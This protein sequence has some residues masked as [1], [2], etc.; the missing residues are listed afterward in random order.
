MSIFKKDIS[1][2]FLI[3][4]VLLY[5]TG[6]AQSEAAKAMDEQILAIGE[7]TS[8]SIHAIEAAE[9]AYNN[10]SEKEQRQVK[11]RKKLFAARDAYSQLRA[12]EADAYINDIGEVTLDSKKA[13]SNAE[14]FLD[15]LTDDECS[16]VKRIEALSAAR[17]SFSQLK[18]AEVDSLIKSI[19]IVTIDSKSDIDRA[20][21]AYRAL[22]DDER[23]FVEEREALD[24]AKASYDDACIKEVENHILSALNDTSKINDAESAYKRLPDA[25]K[26]RVSNYALLQQK[27]A[28]IVVSEIEKIGEVTL[29]SKELI[30]AAERAYNAL[31]DSTRKLVNNYNKLTDAQAS[32]TQL[33]KQ[34]MEAQKQRLLSKMNVRTDEVE[35]MTW[36]HSKSKP[37]YINT[38]SYVL[39]YIGHPSKLSDFPFLRLVYVYAGRDWVFYKKAIIVTDNSKYTQ[40]FNYF[41]VQ[42][43]TTFGGNLCE[44]VD[45][46]ADDNTIEMLKDIASSQKA[47]IRFEGDTHYSDFTVSESD[48]QA[49]QDVIDLYELLK[50]S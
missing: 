12:D 18:A 24:S 40:A 8:E 49:I 23:A 3:L 42:R 14:A 32:F 9:K 33:K 13:I 2:V 38:R 20:E 45:K 50:A 44:Y 4:I 39:P 5:S 27:K 15:S 10:M 48:K 36:Y 17:T 6:C 34:D 11:K 26:N 35:G 37:R 30:E 7:V 19:G 47:I 31:D 22:S 16:R 1:C 21:K 29:D 25:L 28:D 43:E 41:D 46:L